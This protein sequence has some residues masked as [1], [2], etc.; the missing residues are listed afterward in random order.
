M[1]PVSW[2]A[3]EAVIQSAFG[4]APT[5][6]VGPGAVRR[7]SAAGVP[8]SGIRVFSLVFGLP[9]C[10]RGS[11]GLPGRPSGLPPKYPEE[12][13]RCH[14][15]GSGAQP[16]RQQQIMSESVQ[17]AHHTNPGDAMHRHPAEPTVLHP[18]VRMF[19]ELAPPI[20]RFARIARRPRVVPYAA[21]DNQSRGLPRKLRQFRTNRR[22]TASTASRRIPDGTGAARQ[23]CNRRSRLALPARAARPRTGARA[24]ALRTGGSGGSA[25]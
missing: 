13:C 12:F 19:G 15:P 2:P 14:S 5:A 21:W 11:G 8:G 3:K 25:K 7:V 9:P 23:S 10:F 4:V 22:Q 16:E 1:S 24:L 6:S 18:R 20:D 17:Q